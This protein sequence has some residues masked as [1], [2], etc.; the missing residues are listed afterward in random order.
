[1]SASAGILGLGVLHPLLLGGLALGAAPIIIHLL[2]RRRFRR[3]EWAA[4]RFLLEAERENR[5]R[6]QFEQW[7]LLALRCA[8]M[9]LLALLLAR[10]FLRPGLISKLLGGRGE[11]QRI[12]VIDDSASLA[13]RDGATSDLERLKQAAD[14]LLTWLAQEAAGDPLTLIAAS[15]PDAPLIDAVPLSEQGLAS[16]R[17]EVRRVVTTIGPARPKPVFERIAARLAAGAAGSA[18]VYVLSDFQRS[19]WISAADAAAGAFEPLRAGGADGAKPGAARVVLVTAGASA[20]PNATVGGVRMERSQTMAGVPAVVLADVVNHSARP[21]A[22]PALQVQ[23]DGAPLPSVA[24]ESVDAGSSR[25]ASFEVTFA[26]EGYHELAVGLASADGFP[27]DD[28]RRVAVR[29]KP[30]L[31]VLLVD[32]QPSADPRADEVFLLRSA[33]APPGQFASGIRLDTIDPDELDATDLGIYDLV[34]LC[35][36]RPPG[37][38]TAESLVRYVRGGGG[39]V[40]TLGTEVGDGRA[41][42]EALRAG[43]VALLPLPLSDIVSSEQAGGIGLIRTTDHPVTAIF[44][45]SSDS[46]SEFVRFRRFY[47]CDESGGADSAAPATAEA[48][49]QPSAPTVLARFTDAKQ[50]AALVEKAVELGRVLLF[51]STIDSDWN[52][53]PAAPDGSYVVTMLEMVQY[54][55]RRPDHPSESPAGEPLVLPLLPEQYEL[56]ATFRSPSYPDEP[57]VQA[58]AS[59]QDV[60]PGRPVLLTGPRATQLG[61]YQVELTPR[62]APAQ[63]RPLCV[64]LDAAESDL[65]VATPVE[66]EAA[67]SGIPH[68]IVAADAGFLRNGEGTRRELWRTL[69]LLLLAALVAEQGLAWMFGAARARRTRT[70]RA[71]HSVLA[72]PR[73]R[74][75]K[76]RELVEA[77]R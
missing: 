67:L 7:L 47:R 51:T 63:F 69:A 17:D 65:A 32:G 24:L 38:P 31:A 20:R 27:L 62:G 13:Y 15:R 55:A 57:M 52:N 6:V 8:A 3:V 66:L 19:D 61:V 70:P 48:Q 72:S 39:L 41:Y 25:R 77:A 9:M 2:S 14:R 73:A 30:A 68:E 54:A 37:G 18:D 75:R 16:A 11:S 60:L 43:G 26:D 12:V 50:S 10:P 45:A 46:L 36:V 76:D 4:T 40:L 34:F 22:Q 71:A 42:D 1:M 53:W 64:N 59:G 21:L 28:V 74:R 56:S 23:I 58:T 44:P 33:L 5:R 35:N 29:V 49:S